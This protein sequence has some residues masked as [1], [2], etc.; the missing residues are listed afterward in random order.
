MSE[1]PE[2][3]LELLFEKD[4]VRAR[5]LARLLFELADVELDDEG[6]F[7]VTTCKG[8]VEPAHI[9]KVRTP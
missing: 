5:T 8:F 6:G 3:V 4:P 2:V 1:R 7:T 9:E